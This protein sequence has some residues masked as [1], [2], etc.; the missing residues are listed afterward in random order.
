ME[1]LVELEID[2]QDEDYHR[3]RAQGLS[4][5]QAARQTAQDRL[6]F[7]GA[8]VTTAFVQD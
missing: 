8:Q 5:E 2:V 7:T 3:Y 6:G 1:L 4:E